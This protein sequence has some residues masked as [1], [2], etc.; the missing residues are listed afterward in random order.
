VRKLFKGADSSGCGGGTRQVQ[1]ES[2]EDNSAKCSRITDGAESQIPYSFR[3]STISHMMRIRLVDGGD[4]LFFGA[5]WVFEPLPEAVSTWE[6]Q[7]TTPRS[8][9]VPT[10][11]TRDR[12]LH[13]DDGFRLDCDVR[14]ADND[15][16]LA[17]QRR[18]VRENDSCSPP[19][20]LLF[21]SYR[22]RTIDGSLVS[23][24][25]LKDLE[26][27]VKSWNSPEDYRVLKPLGICRESTV[28]LAFRTRI[29]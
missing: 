27:H 5:Q 23:G 29:V 11:E 22:V 6:T 20:R 2:M 7:P 21:Y 19:T 15:V 8:D 12:R 18:G 10:G 16:S 17:Q 1:V 4:W 13:G 24:C 9:R 26:I 14:Y 28:E 3:P 25:F